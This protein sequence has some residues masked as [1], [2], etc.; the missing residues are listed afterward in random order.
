MSSRCFAT[1]GSSTTDLQPS[2]VFVLGCEPP[3]LHLHWSVVSSS[4]MQR[5][6]LLLLATVG[7]VQC[8]LTH[9]YLFKPG[10]ALADSVGGVDLVLGQSSGLDLHNND[11]PNSDHQNA[12]NFP[13]GEA[14]EQAI[15]PT[16]NLTNEYSAGWSMC[17][18]YFRDSP[19]ATFVAAWDPVYDPST[20]APSD[21]RAHA[22]YGHQF[23]QPQLHNSYTSD[24]I[25]NNKPNTPEGCPAEWKHFCVTYDTPGTVKPA[26]YENG[27]ALPQVNGRSNVFSVM[28]SDC[29]E[30]PCTAFPQRPVRCSDARH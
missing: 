6:V 8:A 15:L 9:R 4:K 29:L 30:D 16:L 21:I 13:G 27:A 7:G 3:G 1:S 19:G 20:D 14:F 12:A 2:V 17:Y 22:Y 23:Q 18:W 10:A 28:N 26:F 24:S 11:G 25:C 5:A